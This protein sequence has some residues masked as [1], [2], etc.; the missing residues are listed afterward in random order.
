MARRLT[1]GVV[2]GV[3]FSI[4]I[5]TGFSSGSASAAESDGVVPGDA[6]AEQTVQIVADAAPADS[7]VFSDDRVP[8]STAANSEGVPGQR[9]S[10][11]QSPGEESWTHTLG[12]RPDGKSRSS[13]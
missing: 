7:T 9:S 1:R 11:G 4:V 8:A 13:R 5:A 6:A 3:T 2:S 12:V 10:V